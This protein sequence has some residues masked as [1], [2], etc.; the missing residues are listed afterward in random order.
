MSA[1]EMNVDERDAFLA[2]LHVAVLAVASGNKR[3]PLAVPVFYRYEPGG[4]F[5]FFTNTE[6]R[7]ARKVELIRDAGVVSV[8][9]QKEDF[10]YKYVRVEAT[11]ISIDQPA[12]FDGAFNVARRYMPEEMARGFVQSEL[13]RADSKFTLITVR[14]ERWDSHD[15]S[16]MGG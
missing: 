9:I 3:P 5:S 13:D 8:T 7:S 6:G 11:V 10:P 2:E 4:D 16:K 14:P 12:P 1:M 15:F